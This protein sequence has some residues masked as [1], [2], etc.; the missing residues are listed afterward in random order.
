MLFLS[1]CTSV[2]EK[3][4]AQDEKTLQKKTVAS[5]QTKAVEKKPKTPMGELKNIFAK[6][7]VSDSVFMQVNKKSIMGLLGRTT[8]HSGKL[9]FSKGKLRIDFIKP[10]PSSI[11][12][13]DQDVILIKSVKQG[14]S[15]KRLI[16]KVNRKKVQKQ[17]ALMGLLFG[18]KNVWDKLKLIKTLPKGD[19][20]SLH[21]K[22]MKQSDLPGVV[23]VAIVFDTATKEVRAIKQVDDSENEVQFMFS[24]ML[25]DIN[26][27]KDY[28]NFKLAKGDEVTEL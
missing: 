20:V 8:E 11:I 27:K 28:F 22:P 18:D 14:L 19:L 10:E 13:N 26:F 1:A 25:F 5:T 6:Y 3:P 24:S 12:F 9:L 23:S 16:T 15:E 21:F 2:A 17:N 7:W 4:L